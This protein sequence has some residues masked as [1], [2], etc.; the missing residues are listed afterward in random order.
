MEAKPLLESVTPGTEIFFVQNHKYGNTATCT[1][2]CPILNKLPKFNW[3]LF[4]K[5]YPV[6]GNWELS[7][8]VCRQQTIAGAKGWNPVEGHLKSFIQTWKALIRNFACS[9]HNSQ[10]QSMR[11]LIIEESE[12]K[13][14]KWE[15][16]IVYCTECLVLIHGLLELLTR[17]LRKYALQSYAL[18]CV[19]LL[20]SSKLEAL[21]EKYSNH[22]DTAHQFRSRER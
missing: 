4:T 6:H 19:L 17:R 16:R 9:C 13:S 18:E 14:G 11:R 8:A 7:R 5:W 2:N 20:K 1:F 3:E 21:L 12:T 22:Q 10:Q 15:E